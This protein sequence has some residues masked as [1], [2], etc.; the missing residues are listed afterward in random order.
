MPMKIGAG[1]VSLALALVVS[2]GLRAEE[3]RVRA[4]VLSGLDLP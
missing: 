3:V 2:F 4:G 1:P